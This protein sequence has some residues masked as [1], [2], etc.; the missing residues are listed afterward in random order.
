MRLM[1]TKL[2]DFY[3]KINNAAKRLRPE[4]EVTVNGLEHLQTAKLA[5]SSMGVIE[6]GIY[7]LTKD[8]DLARIEIRVVPQLPETLQTAIIK[9]IQKDGTSKTTILETIYLSEPGPEFYYHDSE[10]VIDHRAPHGE[11]VHK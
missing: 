6:E 7:N 3:K 5:S 8:E 11:N 2:P 1:H 10:E 4:T 9:G